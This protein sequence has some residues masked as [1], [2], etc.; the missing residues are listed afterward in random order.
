MIKESDLLWHARLGHL[1][2]HNLTVLRTMSTGMHTIK[3]DT[4]CESCALTKSKEQPHKGKIA[5]G[6]RKFEIISID[7]CGPFRYLGS[8]S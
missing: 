8:N 7:I 3:T 5:R 6:T 1:G 2:Q 4:L